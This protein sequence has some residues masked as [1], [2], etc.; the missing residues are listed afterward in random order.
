V[1]DKFLFDMR[2][3]GWMIVDK[4]FSSKTTLVDFVLA[5]VRDYLSLQPISIEFVGYFYSKVIF[6]EVTSAG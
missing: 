5:S 6:N 4:Y 2:R 1:D 3:V